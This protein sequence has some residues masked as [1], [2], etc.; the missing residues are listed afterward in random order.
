M[1]D[2]E[3]R[4][5]ERLFRRKN[6]ER[7]VDGGEYYRIDDINAFCVRSRSTGLGNEDST[8]PDGTAKFRGVFAEG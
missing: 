5:N 8:D 2:T 1:F 3:E 7:C 6:L 4:L